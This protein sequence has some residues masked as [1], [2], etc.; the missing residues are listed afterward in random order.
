[1]PVCPII[2][3]GTVKSPGCEEEAERTPRLPD[4]GHSLGAKRAAVAA[5]SSGY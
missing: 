1:M 5:I 2:A 3:S 4:V